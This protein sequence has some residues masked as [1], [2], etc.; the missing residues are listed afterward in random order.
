M[1]LETLTEIISLGGRQFSVDPHA[2]KSIAERIVEEEERDRSVGKPKD[3]DNDNDPDK[4]KSSDVPEPSEATLAMMKALPDEMRN[5]IEEYRRWL[6]VV[7]TSPALGS[8]ERA[9]KIDELLLDFHMKAARIPQAETAESKASR[10]LVDAGLAS[11]SDATKATLAGYI[12]EGR[13]DK[14]REFLADWRGVAEHCGRTSAA[15]N[16]KT[17]AD[18]IAYLRS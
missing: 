9:K 11:L 18:G 5:L 10:M 8:G 6:A 12:R 1:A 16:V 15:M 3:A 4:S 2:G 14:V 13:T 17:V 7:I